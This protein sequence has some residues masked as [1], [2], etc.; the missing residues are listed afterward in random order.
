MPFQSKCQIISNLNLIWFDSA[1]C[2]RLKQHL[3]LLKWIYLRSCVWEAAFQ[4][5]FQKIIALKSSHQDV[6]FYIAIL[7]L[8]RNSLK[9]TWDGAQ[10]LVSLQ[11][12]RSSIWPLVQNIYISS[13][14]FAEQLLLW[15]T[16][17]NL[18]L[19]LKKLEKKLGKHAEHFIER[20]LGNKTTGNV[21]WKLPSHLLQIFANN[22]PNALIRYFQCQKDPLK[23]Y[24]QKD[25]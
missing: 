17:Q 22:F 10:L 14:H 11:V 12:T 25:L 4:E 9:N 18:F 8:W 15:N 21:R 16:F 2:G 5:C 6:Y 3:D 20:I 13:H 24:F 23:S 1:E 7:N 19:C